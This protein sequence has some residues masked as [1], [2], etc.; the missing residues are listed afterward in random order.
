MNKRDWEEMEDRSNEK[1]FIGG[2]IGAFLFFVA[3]C[4][5]VNNVPEHELCFILED[6]KQPDDWQCIE[7][8]ESIC[9]LGLPDQRWNCEVCSIEGLGCESRLAT[10]EEYD[11]QKC[12][13]DSI[14]NSRMIKTDIFS[15]E[16]IECQRYRDAETKEEC[17][18]EDVQKYGVIFCDSEIGCGTNNRCYTEEEAKE[19]I[20][21][22][23]A[24]YPNGS[25]DITKPL[26]CLKQKLV[27]S[28]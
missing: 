15:E 28:D 19:E 1:Y 20:Y 7:W 13:D 21:E 10:K 5:I 16:C 18:L 14:Y 11:L 17:R 22:F 12:L 26:R 25:G 24:K 4:V 6:V 23:L 9:D 27:C 8:K 3:I 2:L